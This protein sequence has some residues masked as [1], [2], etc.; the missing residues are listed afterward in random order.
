M[1]SDNKAVQTCPSHW[2]GSLPRKEDVKRLRKLT[3]P[4][5]ESYDYFL[6]EGLSRGVKAIEPAEFAIVEPQKLRNE[7]ESVDLSELS[8]VKF[9][10]E[11]A[12]IGKPIKAFSGGRSKE[13]LLP[14]ECRE[15]GM[16]YS[17]PLRA[18]FCYQIIKRRNGVEFPQ[19]VTRLPKEFGDLPVMVGSKACH[20]H[21]TTPKQLNVLNEEVS[22]NGCDGLCLFWTFWLII[23]LALA[24]HA[25]RSTRQEATLL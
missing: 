1:K 19:P 14:R 23:C 13:N 10:I 18:M 11:N 2:N 21:N 5:V 9:W 25:H 12:R 4:H 6:E 16:M 24:A 15:R 8:S 22:C 20:L 17:G 7:P 3:A